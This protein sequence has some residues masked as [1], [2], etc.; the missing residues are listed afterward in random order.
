MERIRSKGG[1]AKEVDRSGEHRQWKRCSPRHAERQWK[2]PRIPR[3][4]ERNS[5]EHQESASSQRKGPG[6]GSGFGH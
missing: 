6:S 2:H 1:G 3:H 5:Q 4:A